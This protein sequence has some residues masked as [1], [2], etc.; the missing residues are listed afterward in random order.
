[1]SSS[2]PAKKKSGKLLIGVGVI[3]L[4]AVGA[5]LFFFFSSSPVGGN[6]EKQ[7]M[8]SIADRIVSVEAL[9]KD[10]SNFSLD[11]S[12]YPPNAVQ[13]ISYFEEG[14]NQKWQGQALYDTNVVFEGERSLGLVSVDRNEAL[15]YF[16]KDIDLSQMNY[17]AFMMH[18]S[19]FSAFESM[20]LAFGDVELQ[21]YY[22]YS[23]SNLQNGWN[24][25]KIPRDQF[26]PF[27]ASD[28]SF[29]WTK[30]QRT[31][32]TLLSRFDSVFTVR[33]DRLNVVNMPDEFGKDWKVPGGDKEQ[34]FNLYLHNGK[35]R[36]SARNTG[37][38]R[39]ILG[40]LKNENDFVYSATVSP[41]SA[42]RSGLFVRGN[43]T[44]GY[45]YYFLV[46]G[47]GD[48][49]W[50]ILKFNPAGWDTLASGT[51]GNNTIQDDKDYIVRVEAKG[52]QMRFLLSLN[53]TEYIDI[54]EI[55]DSEFRSGGLGITVIDGNGWTVFD[56]FF[57]KEL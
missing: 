21:N 12:I 28:A 7:T 50:Q 42:S 30:I 5:G 52:P 38:N 57:V 26:V 20:E 25:V 49:P 32:F 15:A 53:G 29:D 22:A 36:L 48:N 24:F 33:L 3:F 13:P 51:L 27:I 54:Q 31:Q 37:L 9:T 11:S 19:D 43:Y 18:I 8:S 44:N 34:F 23:F 6:K 40:N 2:E 47:V 16:K 10:N 56:D 14:E 17:V 35:M 45:G 4:L 41:Q 1:M 55:K 46:G 39:A